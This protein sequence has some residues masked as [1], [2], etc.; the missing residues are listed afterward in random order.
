M[1]FI[2]HSINIWM[3]LQGQVG[4]DI[5]T[6]RHRCWWEDS[7]TGRESNWHENN[8]WC[9]LSFSTHDASL[10]VCTAHNM[11]KPEKPR[12]CYFPLI[13]CQAQIC[14]CNF[15]WVHSSF[16][17]QSYVRCSVCYRSLFLCIHSVDTLLIHTV[18]YLWCSL[19]T[20][21][22]FSITAQH[23]TVRW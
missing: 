13:P 6:H 1:N 9:T 15:T 10:Y 22:N 16:L 4:R 8:H 3:G 12:W 20:G 23:F 17:S 14:D 19:S 2:L 11:N 7:M 5:A 21:S 18:S